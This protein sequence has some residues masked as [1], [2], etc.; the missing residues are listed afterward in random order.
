ME[1]IY[2]P[3]V[4]EDICDVHGCDIFGNTLT[5]PFD[6]KYEVFE[7]EGITRTINSLP[8]EK[9]AL[10][11]DITNRM[12][13]F[14]ILPSLPR[15]AEPVVIPTSAYAKKMA[16]VAEAKLREQGDG[17]LYLNNWIG[18]IDWG[19]DKGIK[20]TEEALSIQMMTA[21][22][23]AVIARRTNKIKLRQKVTV[24]EFSNE[25]S[26]DDDEYVL[27][28]PERRG[29]RLRKDPYASQRFERRY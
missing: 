18:T 16:A 9:P 27:P 6:D 23:Q 15:A 24:T 20:L 14:D 13:A 22:C 26:D 3:V 5:N 21:A 10:P 28:S 2:I 12:I 11:M 4:S 29:I 17:R 25:H 8:T 1:V 7:D 19:I